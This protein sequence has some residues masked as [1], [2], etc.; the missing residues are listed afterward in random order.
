[1]TSKL[2]HDRLEEA[3]YGKLSIADVIGE[4]QPPWL[5]RYVIADYVGDYRLD[6]TRGPDLINASA[7]MFFEDAGAYIRSYGGSEYGHAF[8]LALFAT[9]L[10][11]E[12]H[13]YTPDAEFLV[14]KPALPRI[15]PADNTW[16]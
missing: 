16:A 8:N 2:R 13:P 10:V 15:C 6:P 5:D 9:F 3:I 11:V 7:A 14:L 12:R 1:M 4:Q